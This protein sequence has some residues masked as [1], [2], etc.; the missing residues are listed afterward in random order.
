MKSFAVIF[1][2]LLAACVAKKEN[3]SDT[4]LHVVAS[5]SPN[6]IRVTGTIT[7]SGRPDYRIPVDPR[8]AGASAAPVDKAWTVTANGIGP[9]RAGMTVVE[10]N[11]A[12]GGFSVPS[13]A[14]PACSYAN[15]K[16]AP[17]GLAVMLENNKIAR[18]EIRS[19]SIPTAEGAR[20]GDNESRIRSLYSGRVTTSVHKYVTGGHY[21]TVTPVADT[22][23]RIVFETDGK[24]VTN[25]RAGVLPAVEYVER[26]G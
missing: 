4:L 6:Q 12:V 26:C 25:Y 2:C 14:D 3:S 19:G 13:G 21:L 1:V 17:D 11:K 15:L 8:P 23:H 22:T 9:L 5:P 10:A 24:V 18:V 7:D 16:N 20:I